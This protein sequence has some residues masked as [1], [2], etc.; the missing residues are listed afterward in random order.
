MSTYIPL[1]VD[2]NT[3]LISKPLHGGFITVNQEN[4]EYSY[5]YGPSGL[6]GLLHT[7]YAVLCALAASL[8]GITFGYDQGVIANVLVMKDFQERF[9]LSPFQIG[10]L[11]AVLELGA[12]FG[13]LGAGSL[14][15]KLS[16]R[17]SIILSSVVFCI[18]S[19]L[20]TIALDL[21]ILM[22]GRC[23]G[24]VGIGA[25]SMLCPLYI[26]E[27]ASPETRGSLI[28]LE[29]FS[30]V[31]GVVLGFWVGFA[32]RTLDGAAS[33]R[34]PLGLQVVLGLQLAIGAL[35]LPPSP[36]LLVFRGKETEALKTLA[37]LRDRDES[38]PLLQ[39]E[40]AE[41]RVE[42]RLAYHFVKEGGDG[43]LD[44]F[45]PNLISR[46]MIGVAAMFFQQ[47]S[48]INAL[49]YYGPLLMARI[50][51]EGDSVSLIMSGFINIV[52]LLAVVPAMFLLDSV[53]RK[54]LLRVGTVL[55]ALSHLTVAILIYIGSEDW[56]SHQ[57]LA[58]G[59]VGSI[60]MFTASYGT[61]IGPIAWVLA[62]EVF[63]SGRIRSKGT[64]ISTASNWFNNFLVGLVTP[65]L[66]EYSPI[67]TFALLSSACGAAY[68]W[69]TVFV[70][71]TKG[72]SLEEVD[73]LFSS[74]MGRIDQE[75][76]KQ[77][78]EDVG[79]PDIV[80]DIVDGA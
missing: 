51:L 47:W 61:S 10:L 13:A 8:G 1:P 21:N 76:R 66:I 32:T 27:M 16:R 36:R 78:Y 57:M 53:G 39:L 46:T 19:L 79:I 4:G 2:S 52:Q 64:S 60:Y 43:W 65:A 49:L 41:M 6:K 54:P 37:R 25:L 42:A 14:A 80:R 73:A 44:L 75:R 74:S 34:I 77:A 69:S 68:V 62:N 7:R 3:S 26:S 38:D 67:L 24:G 33:W 9:P 70:P 30:I 45:G 58:W 18:G 71:E 63:P 31:S 35:W 12:L 56:P 59:A 55:M 40:L 20:Q 48:G 50:G 23:I 11:T 29:Q 15:N 28:S 72:L 5:A 22:A 17:D